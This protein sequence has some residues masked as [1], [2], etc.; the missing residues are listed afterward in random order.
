MT[1]ASDDRPGTDAITYTGN[2]LDPAFYPERLA[3]SLFTNHGPI[4]S[5]IVRQIVEDAELRGQIA[6]HL[7]RRQ[8]RAE[9]IA[10]VRSHL[11]DK[12]QRVEDCDGENVDVD[13]TEVAEA[14]V[15]LLC[16]TLH[17]SVKAL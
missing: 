14:I 4:G 2:P 1:D 15:D 17:I 11:P 7:R 6:D 12:M 9:R 5:N 16:P 3:H 8:Q 10:L 13:A